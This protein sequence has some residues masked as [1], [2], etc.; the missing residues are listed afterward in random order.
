MRKFIK[1]IVQNV[2]FVSLTS[3]EI[4]SMD[5]ASWA[6]YWWLNYARSVS[7]TFDVE[8]ATILFGFVSSS[9]ILLIMNFLQWG[10]KEEELASKV[11]YFDVDGVK[12]FQGLKSKVTIQ[13]QY[14]YFSFITSVHYMIHETN[15]VVQ[16]FWNILLV[17]SMESLLQCIYV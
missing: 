6:T 11:V 16:T 15:L 17:S 7:N 2:K 14:Q 4:T 9:L 1:I 12:T 13:I 5:N 10:L 8:C 3:H